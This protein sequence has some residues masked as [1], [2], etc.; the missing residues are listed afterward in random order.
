MF[1]SRSDHAKDY[2]SQVAFEQVNIPYFGPTLWHSYQDGITEAATAYS[3]GDLMLLCSLYP[4]EWTISQR[5]TYYLM[6]LVIS[7][8]HIMA[9]FSFT[10]S[11]IATWWEQQC[12][13]GKKLIMVGNIRFLQIANVLDVGMISPGTYSWKTSS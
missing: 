8:L 12:E 10:E 7:I 2:S 1:E 9:M 6:S 3:S 5:N 11:H 4:S 13:F